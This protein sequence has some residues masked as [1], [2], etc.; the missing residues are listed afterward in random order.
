MAVDI[1][2]FGGYPLFGLEGGGDG[3][4]HFCLKM[5]VEHIPPNLLDELN[6]FWLTSIAS[7]EPFFLSRSFT[8]YYP[9]PF[10]PRFLSPTTVAAARGGLGRGGEAR[11]A[12]RR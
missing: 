3:D 2:F 5:M 1:H 11:A 4:N 12:R 7:P 10:S 8:N 9:F 6:H